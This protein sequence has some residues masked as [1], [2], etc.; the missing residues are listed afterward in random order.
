MPDWR[1]SKKKTEERKTVRRDEMRSSR[2]CL[3]FSSPYFALWSCPI[4]SYD[5][6][7]NGFNHTPATI[8]SVHWRWRLIFTTPLGRRALYSTEQVSSGLR[9]QSVYGGLP[10]QFGA[11]NSAAQ[12][13][14]PPMPSRRPFCRP[15]RRRLAWFGKKE[16]MKWFSGRRCWPTLFR[17]WLTRTRLLVDVWVVCPHLLCGRW[18]GPLRSGSNRSR[19]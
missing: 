16:S 12:I 17:Q 18:T 6:I 15:H 9:D 13:K 14:V 19:F 3:Y 4:R 8:D 10:I 1:R 5:R 7:L 2:Q 11:E